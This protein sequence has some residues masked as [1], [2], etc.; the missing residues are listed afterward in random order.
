MPADRRAS[1]IQ[2]PSW[3]HSPP[4]TTGPVD[5]LF[6][7]GGKDSFLALRKLQQEANGNPVVLVTTFCANER[8]VAHQELELESIIRQAEQL[9]LPLLGIPLHPGR[10]YC[11]AVEPAIREV[12]NA[13]RLVFG[14]LHL[15]HIREWREEAFAAICEELELELLFPLW[16]ADYETLMLDLEKSGVVCEVSAVTEAARGLVRQGEVF[17]RKLYESLPDTV[18]AFGEKGEFHTLVK[19]RDDHL[20]E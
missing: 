7:S 1:V 11:E 6:W 20:I 13:A 16:E 14:D 19:I 4:L 12:K 2:Q 5:L 17:D 8:R 18:D 9:E 15:Q 10:D 3:L